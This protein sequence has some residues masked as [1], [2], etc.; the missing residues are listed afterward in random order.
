MTASRIINLVSS[1][2]ATGLADAPT[3]QATTL[4]PLWDLA[5]TLQ[6]LSAR[7]IGLLKTHGVR[8]GAKKA[9]SE[10]ANRTINSDMELATSD[11]SQ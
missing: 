3:K 10:F 5:L 6:T 7:T 9:S 1:S 2:T 8:A 11:K 4:L